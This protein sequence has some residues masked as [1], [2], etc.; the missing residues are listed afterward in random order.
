MVIINVAII[1]SLSDGKLYLFSDCRQATVTIA[2]TNPS[3]FSI[4]QDNDIGECV[5]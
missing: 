5:T 2:M 4:K 3:V 1:I